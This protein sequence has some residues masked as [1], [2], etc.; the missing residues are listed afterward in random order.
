MRK[1]I[2]I[3]FLVL[4]VAGWG[5][6]YSLPSTNVFDW[7]QYTGIPGG[8]PSRTTYTNLSAGSSVA[9]IQNALDVCP[10]NQA[11]K[12]LTGSTSLGGGTL[13]IPDFVSLR[14]EGFGTVLTSVG[15]IRMGDGNGPGSRTYITISSGATRGSSN[16]TVS[17][18]PTGLS[19]GSVFHITEL[20]N[21]NIGVN[22]NGYEEDITAPLLC[23]YCDEANP[24]LDGTYVRG[25][26]VQATAISGSDI[27]FDPPLWTDF[28]ESERIEY[29]PSGSI[30]GQYRG[31][32]DIKVETSNYAT[33]DMDGSMYC[34]ATNVYFHILTGGDAALRTHWSYRC[35][36]EH[37]DFKGF[38]NEQPT[39]ILSWMHSFYTRIQNNSFDTITQNITMAG[40]GG[41]HAI[42]WNYINSET[43]NGFTSIIS[44]ITSHGAHNDFTLLEGNKW[45]KLDFDSIH[46][47]AGRGTIF[48]NWGRAES[49]SPEGK[50]TYG[51]GAI[52]IDSWNWYFQCVANILGHPGISGWGYSVESTTDQ[53]GEEFLWV[54]GFSGYN[55]W[56]ADNVSSRLL[57]HNNYDYVN[58]GIVDNIGGEST[59][60]V[61]S[62]IFPSKP[63]WVGTLA[64]PAIG[65]DTTGLYTN[66]IPAEYRFLTGNDPP[67]EGGSSPV[68]TF[69]GK[70]SVQGSAILQ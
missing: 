10:T 25:Q 23:D 17:S 38:V 49:L 55:P 6:T 20:N 24:S 52:Q 69:S 42:A 44:D 62:L 37:C 32:E 28:T 48:R 59:N 9:A 22:P 14:G 21:T 18:T 31:L 16:I 8:I 13:T 27:T 50:T 46:G 34:W 56:E 45:I 35:Q 30:L 36:V 19:V 29:P 4:P 51:F 68:G 65:P 11:V 66:Q 41:G 67:A 63:T 15:Q 39:G 47:S 12:L 64:F 3:L 43:N 53:A 26:A 2:S 40:R 7:A 60:H 54:L 33:L 1:L 70:V 61:A 5:A 57:R 58:G